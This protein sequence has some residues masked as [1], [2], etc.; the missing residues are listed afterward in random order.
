M[1]V[2]PTAASNFWTLGEPIRDPI[3]TKQ[4]TDSPLL[5]HVQLENVMMPDARELAFQIEHKVLAASIGGQPLYTAIEHE[6]GKT[7]VMTVDLQQGDLPLRT[8]FPIMMTNAISWFRGERAELR[9]SLATGSIVECELSATVVSD[10]SDTGGVQAAGGRLAAADEAVELAAT[11]EP[12]TNAN[13]TVLVLRA[14]DGSDRRLPEN[15]K[16]LMLGPLDQC[17][18]WQVIRTNANGEASQPTSSDKAAVE[19]LETLA[20]YA[21]NLASAAESDLRAT[22]D[23]TAE[24]AAYAGVWGGRPIWF[25]LIVLG[26]LLSAIEW[27]MYQRRWIS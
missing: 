19:P 13:E 9:Q 20:Q 10:D 15:V 26:L 24:Q 11:A 25:Y 5:T 22:P 8:A 27:C 3:I 4:D 12:V 18:V 21:C 2:Q 23:L 17:G 16:R 7:L 14:P 1:V 6:G